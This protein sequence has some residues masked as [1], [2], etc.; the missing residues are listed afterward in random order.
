[1]TGR[2]SVSRSLLPAFRTFPLPTRP[3]AVIAAGFL[4]FFLRALTSSSQTSRA[5]SGSKDAGQWGDEEEAIDALGLSHTDQCLHTGAQGWSGGSQRF[6]GGGG[7]GRRL[8]LCLQPQGGFLETVDSSCQVPWRTHA[9]RS[10]SPIKM[11]WV[12]PSLSC[13]TT[14][15]TVRT[16]PLCLGNPRGNRKWSLKNRPMPRVLGPAL[17]KQTGTIC[18]AVCSQLTKN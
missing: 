5:H 14:T 7:A 17:H 11:L 12:P 2:W 18:E 13:V 1:M 9:S 4:S 6:W 16:G 15:P 10:A 8:L 3:P